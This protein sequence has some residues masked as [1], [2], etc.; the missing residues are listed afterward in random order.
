ML[1][2]FYGTGIRRSELARLNWLDLDIERKT[3][4]VRQGKGRKDRMVPNRATG[5]GVDRE[6]PGRD[7]PPVRQ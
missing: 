5:V 2:T 7:P 4:M 1:E 6:I 3:L